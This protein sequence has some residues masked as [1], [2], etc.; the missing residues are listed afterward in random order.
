MSVIV[1]DNKN[2]IRIPKKYSKI[3]GIKPGDKALVFATVNQVVIVPLKNKKFIG[4]L[5]GINFNE[6][7]HEASKYLFGEE[8]S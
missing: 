3:A 4:S 1:I 8:S 5:D 6:E 2:R 7:D